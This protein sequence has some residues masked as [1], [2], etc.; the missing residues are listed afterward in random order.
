MDSYISE[1]SLSKFQQGNILRGKK[2]S[3]TIRFHLRL[4][5]DLPKENCPNDPP[6]KNMNDCK[7]RRENVLLVMFNILFF[8]D[9]LHGLST[10][11]QI[12]VELMIVPSLR[13]QRNK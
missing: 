1:M 13:F 8:K 10:D 4:E 5:H 7:L 9:F 6:F 3:I 2:K 12:F 11:M